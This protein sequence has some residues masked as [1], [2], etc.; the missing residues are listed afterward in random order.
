M[1][2]HI[3]GRRHDAVAA[4]LGNATLLGVGYLLVGR[5][6]L[7][8]GTTAITA[9]L[10]GVLGASGWVAVLV[11]LVLWWAVLVVHGFVIAGGRDSARIRRHR[12]IAV[13]VAV[14]VVAVFAALTIRAGSVTSTVEEARAR[15]DCPAATA[16]QGGLWFGPRV[17]AAPAATRGDETVHVCEELA[18]ARRELDRAAGGDLAALASPSHGG[19]RCSAFTQVT[20]AWSR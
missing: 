17:V 14:L 6:R 13:I 12:V 7:A 18:S 1:G 3:G 2:D 19:T 11:L 15:G 20:S 4:A 10:L 8:A 5:P 9:V 16:A